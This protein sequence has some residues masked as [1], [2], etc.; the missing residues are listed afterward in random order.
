VVDFR[1]AVAGLIGRMA[2]GI[3]HGVDALVELL[4]RFSPRPLVQP[5]Y[6]RPKAAWFV[7]RDGTRLS[8]QTAEGWQRV[9]RAFAEALLGG[10]LSWLG[11][12]DTA[13]APG[14]VDAFRVRPAAAVLGGRSGALDE[15]AG[16]LL[17]GDDLTVLVPPG[18]AD[19]DTHAWLARLGELAEASAA[20]L[21]YRLTAERVQ[22]AFDAGLTGPEMLDF[23][24][25][26]S[27]APLPVG[28]RAAIERWWE[29]YG[30]VRLYDEVCL[31]EL[32]DDFLLPELLAATPLRGWLVHTFSPRLIAVEPAAVDN[33]VAALARLG[34]APRVVEG[35]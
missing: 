28:A 31:V 13:G 2:P 11:L 9:A 12:V 18:A 29:G 22:S 25:A 15:E 26:G 20:G 30:A 27:R 34:H 10:P 8:R 24:A 35:G 17:V 33:L 16:E 32:G 23:L 14:R 19:A 7:D 5:A 21:R 1:R 6:H 4:S 3:W